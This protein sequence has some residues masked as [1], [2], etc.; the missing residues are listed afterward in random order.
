M[1][2]NL[3][4]RFQ[5]CLNT[6]DAEIVRLG[7]DGF[8]DHV[9]Q[10]SSFPTTLAANAIN[11]DFIDVENVLKAND[12]LDINEFPLVETYINS[13]PRLEELFSVWSLLTGRRELEAALSAN[14][15]RCFVLILQLLPADDSRYVDIT[16]RVL[17][18]HETGLIR[19]LQS[20]DRSTVAYTMLLLSFCI[21]T[22]KTLSE[23]LLHA[24]LTSFKQLN[25]AAN[26]NKSGKLPVYASFC[27]V[28]LLGHILFYLDHSQCLLVFSEATLLVDLIYH[29]S[30][31][32]L[33]LLLSFQ[34]SL[35]E[36]K[37]ITFL[38]N[39]TYFLN[40]ATVNKLLSMRSK[41]STDEFESVINPYLQSMV[42]EL[43]KELVS[44]SSSMTSKTLSTAIH[45]VLDNLVPQFD[46]SHQQVPTNLFVLS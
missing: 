26:V 41:L 11:P 23:S 19:Q 30:L 24:I 38:E 21:R 27:G 16:Y 7:L 15:L 18:E 46:L 25:A 13:S 5:F 40:D 9:A 2:L 42:E 37:S 34:Q 14:F 20:T 17:R 44:S 4:K 6:D 28:V 45:A 10:Y 36:Q 1:T 32:T 8:A 31:P 43:L 35:L 12:S 39:I 3:I 33:H 29:R 22:H